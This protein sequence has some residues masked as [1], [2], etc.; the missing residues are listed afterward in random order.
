MQN[1][2]RLVHSALLKRHK[3][4]AIVESCTGGL[5]CAQLTS[6]SGSSAYL[7]LGIV[8]YS[9]YSKRKLLG[10]PLNLINRKGAVSAEVAAKMAQAVRKIAKSD[11]GI[12]IT[13]IAGP[14]GATASKPLGT[15]YI[16]IAT[17]RKTL[18]RR[19]QLRG[20]RSAIRKQ[21]VLKAL[22]LLKTLL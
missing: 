21:S 20:S 1:L 7:I 14:T 3:S 9:N 22:Q 15:V 12:G 13:G 2:A 11:F 17:P 6:L 10:I 5:L 8:A 16:A 4:V 19:L 18:C